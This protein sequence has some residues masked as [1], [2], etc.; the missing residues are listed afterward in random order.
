MGGIITKNQIKRENP[1]NVCPLG[2]DYSTNKKCQNHFFRILERKKNIRKDKFKFVDIQFFNR[3]FLTILSV[4][5]DQLFQSE[6]CVKMNA[7]AEIL[8][9]D[10]QQQIACKRNS[11]AGN[12]AKPRINALLIL[13]KYK[14]YF[15][16]AGK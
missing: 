6:S 16:L 2:F 15:P 11:L 10:F 7:K 4:S 14:F 8:C 5:A 13:E 9:A 12:G 3:N 1:S